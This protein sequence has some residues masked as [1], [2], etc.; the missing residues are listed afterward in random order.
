MQT[1]ADDKAAPRSRPQPVH[2]PPRP[3]NDSAH[4]DAALAAAAPPPAAAPPAPALLDASNVPG[5]AQGVQAMF[6]G[7][8]QPA[9]AYFGQAHSACRE[10]A[11]WDLGKQVAHYAA[12]VGILE[13]FAKVDEAA[14]AR[15]S[16][17]AAALSLLM[18][19]HLSYLVNDAVGRNLRAGNF[20]WCSGVLQQLGGYA[21]SIGRP[22]VA[23]GVAARVQQV[24]GSG[25]G[26]ASVP[27]WEAVGGFLARVENA[28]SLPE[29]AGAVASVQAG[30]L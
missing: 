29:I 24:E 4:T 27:Q 9:Q 30:L 16:R 19:D 11:A 1:H 10:A 8:W 12:A 23:Q 15:L 14:A 3:L 18:L 5:F 20:A 17:Y 25:Q 7:Q 22:E 6:A 13:T 2:A 21:A 28:G 26:N